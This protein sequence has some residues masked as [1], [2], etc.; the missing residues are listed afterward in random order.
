LSI[1]LSRTYTPGPAAQERA[2]WHKRY[3]TVAQARVA[4]DNLD[5]YARLANINPHSSRSVLEQFTEQ[6]EPL[7]RARIEEVSPVRVIFHEVS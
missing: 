6:V 2:R 5:D 7:V 4:L 3:V 1:N